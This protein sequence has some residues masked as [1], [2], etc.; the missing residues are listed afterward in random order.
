MLKSGFGTAIGS[1][2]KSRMSAIFSITATEKCRYSETETR[3]ALFPVPCVPRFWV[4]AFCVIKPLLTPP[5]NPADG[6]I[7]DQGYEIPKFNCLS[8]KGVFRCLPRRESDESRISRP[9]C[10]KRRRCLPFSVLFLSFKCVSDTDR[11]PLRYFYAL[12]PFC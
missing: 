8:K 6:R 5:R 11:V 3:P 9:Q 1:P 10:Q 7:S 12:V 4:F 2:S